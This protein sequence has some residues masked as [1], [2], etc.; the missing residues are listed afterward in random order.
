MNLSTFGGRRRIKIICLGSS[1]G[2]TLPFGM[3]LQPA[4][5]KTHFPR[6]CRPSRPPSGTVADVPAQPSV[7][8]IPKAGPAGEMIVADGARDSYRRLP[9]MPPQVDG[10]TPPD[11]QSLLRSRRNCQLPAMASAHAPA[12]TWS[13]LPPPS[14]PPVR[15]VSEDRHRPRRRLHC[16]IARSSIGTCSDCA[17]FREQGGSGKGDSRQ[18]G[19]L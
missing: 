15:M 2:D 5:A 18:R 14:Y 3:R 13:S 4:R 12:N 17:S 19:H 11:G 10:S 6:G 8:A 7:P 9:S 16:A 1:R